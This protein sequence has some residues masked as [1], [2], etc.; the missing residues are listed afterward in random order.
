MMA[1]DDPL[2]LL[3]TGPVPGT[4]AVAVTESGGLVAGKKALVTGA[5]KGIGR[6]VALALAAQGADVGVCDIVRDADTE[7]V[8]E[9]VRSV[10]R[11]GTM[12]IGDLTKVAQIDAVVGSFVAAHGTIDILVH[13]ALDR[14]LEDGRD[15]FWKMEE[16]TWD[17]IMALHV[18]GALFLAQRCARVMRAENGPAR[19]GSIVLFSSTHG[20]HGGSMAYGTAK[21]ATRRLVRSVATA[22]GGT[23]ININAIA[24]GAVLNNLP[25]E[26]GFVL[27]G[28]PAAD[29]AWTNRDGQNPT[30][31]WDN[32]AGRIG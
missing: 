13:C 3:P 29:D 1:D 4:P 6:A 32:P 9:L 21:G 11:Q 10:G 14:S 30:G 2:L 22:L 24:P 17:A 31:R 18:K 16:D 27:D 5:R 19:G 23:G 7:R 20:F 12:H 28:D 26:P 8:A 15:S 25:K